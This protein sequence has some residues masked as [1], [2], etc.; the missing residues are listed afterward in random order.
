MASIGTVA[1]SQEYKNLMLPI[2]TNGT[3]F[4][5]R[6]VTSR[7]FI[8]DPRPRLSPL[9][10]S[11]SSFL[12]ACVHWLERLWQLSEHSYQKESTPLHPTVQLIQTQMLA[13][14]PFANMTPEERLQTA[15]GVQ[16]PSWLV[17]SQEA[18]HIAEA[19]ESTFGRVVTLESSP[20]SAY[21]T[22][23]YELCRISYEAF[24]CTG[25]G[26]LMTLEYDGDLAVASIVETPLLNWAM[27]PITFSA[28]KGL[29]SDDMAGWIDAFIESQSP[30]KL[31]L[32]GSGTEDSLF[33]KALA[34]SRANSYLEDQSSLPSH[35][36]LAM[37]VALATKDAL[38]SYKDDCVE[39][40][41]CEDLRRKADAIA[42]PHRPRKPITWPATGPRHQ[43]L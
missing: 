33:I 35:H 24:E 3:G 15:V 7:C 38:E 8:S 2:L 12:L 1:A 36:I 9:D 21:T 39:A 30:D 28:R 29:T 27:N 18:C 17:G 41:E 11:F 23:G 25:P 19:A 16:I 6:K 4:E 32:A 42:G 20:S 22:A 5:P 13:L 40:K 31:M 37:G 14:P 10:E 34:K 43:E 26:L